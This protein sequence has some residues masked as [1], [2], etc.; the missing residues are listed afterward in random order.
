MKNDQHTEELTIYRVSIG[1]ALYV[2]RLA[3]PTVAEVTLALAECH[4]QD[5]LEGETLT[6][7]DFVEL[8]EAAQKRDQIVD[9]E[10]GTFVSLYEFARR[11]SVA[12]QRAI[13]C[14]EWG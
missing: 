2:M 14:S 8:D 12:K 11:P 7:S 1:G 5:A 4:E 9:D 3:E 6:A 13:A 10:T